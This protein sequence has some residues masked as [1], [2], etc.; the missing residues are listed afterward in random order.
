MKDRTQQPI[1]N[2]ETKNYFFFALIG[3]VVNLF[4]ILMYR[5]TDLSVSKFTDFFIT[6]LINFSFSL[7][8]VE[9]GRINKSNLLKYLAVSEL[10]FSV[11]LSIYF[12]YFIPTDF[13]I[14]NFQNTTRNIID[15]SYFI[16]PLLY[17]AILIQLFRVDK[18]K[19]LLLGALIFLLVIKLIFQNYVSNF[20]DSIWWVLI[21]SI[22][23]IIFI[24]YWFSKYR[25]QKTHVRRIQKIRFH[26]TDK[27][28]KKLKR[29][30]LQGKILFS[31]GIFLI[32]ISILWWIISRFIEDEISFVA[33]NWF[34]PAM[35][36]GLYLS[37][38]G[39]QFK[40]LSRPAITLDESL[41]SVLYLR[42]FSKD[43][44]TSFQIFSG[45]L[46]LGYMLETFYTFEEQLS[47]VVAPIGPMI[48]LAKPHS[49]LPTPGASKH[50][51][52]DNDWQDLVIKL[53]MKA[54]LVVIQPGTSDSVSWELKKAFELLSPCQ[55]ILV[56]QGFKKNEYKACKELLFQTYKIILPEK[57]KRGMFIRFDEEWNPI[58][59]KFG[60]PYFRRT[61]YKPLRSLMNHAL[62]PVFNN[63]EVVWRPSPLSKL[64]MAALFIIGLFVLLIL[65]TLA[66]RYLLIDI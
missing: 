61:V 20:Y 47:D 50:Y 62:E 22:K 60:A 63:L 9:I 6:N 7:A 51:S 36:M 3:V 29:Y 31:L 15:I 55:L 33:V 24:I 30:R 28:T 52:P 16:A 17:G 45:L 34:I 38:R 44:S 46:N 25:F 23:Y 2:I 21:I 18:P 40:S 48:A 39:R 42:P 26:Q 57:L 65:T 32:V 5:F 66:F 64:T 13:A 58:V 14:I 11:L 43:A 1:G 35:L 49:A 59:L 54:K 27:E 56:I 10:I 37:F 12:I 19:R 4:F 41:P 8:V 53:L